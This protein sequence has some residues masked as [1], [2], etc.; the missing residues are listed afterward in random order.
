MQILLLSS[1]FVP[2]NRP[3]E[4]PLLQKLSAQFV[5]LGHDVRMI[6]PGNFSLERIATPLAQ[7]LSP[8]TVEVNDLTE[9]YTRFDTRANSGA[10]LHILKSRTEH[11]AAYGREAMGLAVSQLLGGAEF[12]PETVIVFDDC[13]PLTGALTT[14]PVK[15]AAFTR[16]LDNDADGQELTAFDRVV[17]H[18]PMLA[19]QLLEKAPK[20]AIARRIARGA[21][22]VFPHGS[23][24]SL[25]SLP[26]KA[27]AK[28]SLQNTLG[29][30]VKSGVPLFFLN[31]PMA[32]CIEALPK[33]LTQ[34]I[35]V[36]CKCDTEVIGE[37]LET[38]PDR[39]SVLPADAKNGTIINAVDFSIQSNNPDAVSPCLKS[40]TVPIV[41]EKDNI[42]VL[43]LSCDTLSGTGV[44]FAD[45]S[46]DEAIGKALGIFCNSSA[47]QKLQSRLSHTVASLDHITALY[48]AKDDADT[49]RQS[50]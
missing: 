40:G 22:D 30:P 38:Y 13:M 44:T 18:G 39:L 32:Q 20:T 42:S 27:S 46:L 12:S 4:T 9:T 26:H 10:Q 33:I 28:A 2:E 45:G 7:R 14:C 41:A 35:Q 34:D 50:A 5:K 29:L 49:N 6:V 25:A 15:I 31:I 1:R 17:I 37:F 36:V 16:L 19:A 47:F 24:T 11:P 43:A 21:V 3:A 48:L 23:E 8:V